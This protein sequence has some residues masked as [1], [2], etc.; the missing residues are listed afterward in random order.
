[1]RRQKIKDEEEEEEE[2]EEEK[3]IN[4]E[5]DAEEDWCCACKDGGYLMLCDYMSVPHSPFP[6]TFPDCV[7]VCVYLCALGKV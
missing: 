5:E 6:F 4:K 1:M 3:I 7:S 2:E